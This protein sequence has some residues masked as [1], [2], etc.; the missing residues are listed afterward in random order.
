[1]NIDATNDATTQTERKQCNQRKIH[2]LHPWS[3]VRKKGSFILLS[4]LL[5]LLAFV[6]NA[7]NGTK[8]HKPILESD[9]IEDVDAAKLFRM[10]EEHEYLAVFF[11]KYFFTRFTFV[12]TLHTSNASFC[13]WIVFHH[14]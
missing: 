10:I 6:I 11:C 5:T 13:I 14:L 12:F 8:A 9:V 1:M 3:N 4:T 2:D 7:T